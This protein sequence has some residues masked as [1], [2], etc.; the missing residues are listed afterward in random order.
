MQYAEDRYS[1]VTV[2]IGGGGSKPP[3]LVATKGAA[4]GAL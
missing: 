4:P 1:S 3:A 2:S